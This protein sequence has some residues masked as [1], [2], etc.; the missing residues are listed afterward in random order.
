[1]WHHIIRRHSTVLCHCYVKKFIFSVVLKDSFIISSLCTVIIKNSHHVSMCYHQYWRCKTH[2]SSKKSSLTAKTP[3][4]SMMTTLYSLFVTSIQNL[5]NKPFLI[6][7]CVVAMCLIE[8][9]VDIAG[10]TN[11]VYSRKLLLYMWFNWQGI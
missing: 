11:T 7:R 3:N 2:I 6:S 4:H 9:F 1:V 8:I 5:Q 10:F